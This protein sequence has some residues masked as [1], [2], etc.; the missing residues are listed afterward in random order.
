MALKWFEPNLLS[1]ELSSHLDW[2]DNYSKFMLELW[3]P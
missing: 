2:I 1:D 3:T